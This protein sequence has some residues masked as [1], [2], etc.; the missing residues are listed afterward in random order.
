MP[1]NPNPPAHVSLH[2]FGDLAALAITG[3]GGP[4]VYL[5]PEQARA[6]SRD[7]ARLCRSL[8]RESFAASEYRQDSV[9]VSIVAN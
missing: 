3:V 8:E 5:D 6:L 7:L 1:R 9:P 4:T 2:R